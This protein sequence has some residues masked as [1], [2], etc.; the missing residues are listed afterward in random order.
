M[1]RWADIHLTLPMLMPLQAIFAVVQ[2]DCVA[3]NQN[4]PCCRLVAV[5]QSKATMAIWQ[6]QQIKVDNLSAQTLLDAP[7]AMQTHI[8]TCAGAKQQ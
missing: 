6:L 2:Q 1:V 4:H 3:A 7:V 8:L 5:V